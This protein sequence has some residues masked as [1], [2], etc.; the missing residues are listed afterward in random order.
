[1]N[2]SVLSQSLGP[3]W[4]LTLLLGLTLCSATAS[5]AGEELPAPEQVKARM[6]ANLPA[7][8]R[9]KQAGK[10]GENNQAYLEARTTL[11]QTEEDLV[12]IENEDRKTVYTLLARR[13]KTTVESIQTARAAQ[14][15][16]RSTAGLWLQDTQGDWYRKKSDSPK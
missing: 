13:A 5:R 4:M 16:E 1:M 12:K 9:L 11:T 3:R 14:I 10:V 7:I 2:R 15:R 6:K 8:D